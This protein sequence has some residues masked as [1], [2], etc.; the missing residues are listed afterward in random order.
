MTL[1]FQKILRHF[2]VL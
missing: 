2:A 1:I